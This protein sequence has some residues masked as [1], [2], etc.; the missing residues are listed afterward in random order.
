MDSFQAF[1][2][3]Q[4]EG[5]AHFA[6]LEMMTMGPAAALLKFADVQSGQRVLDVA[7]GTGVVAVTAAPTGARVTGFDLTL[8]CWNKRE[9]TRK[10]PQLKSIGVRAMLK[11]C[12]SSLARL[13]SW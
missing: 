4:R 1:K 11:R 6:P 3:V 8:S 2:K 13:M 12:R 9:K 10:S 7:C 5:W